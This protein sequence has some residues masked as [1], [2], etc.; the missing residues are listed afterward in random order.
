MADVITIVADGIATL[1]EMVKLWQMLLPLWQMDWPYGNNYF[2]LISEML[3]T[4][5]SHM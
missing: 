3:N 1:G 5:S 2:I 4:T